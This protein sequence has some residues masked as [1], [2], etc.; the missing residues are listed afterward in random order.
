M[1]LGVTTLF[2]LTVVI[3]CRLLPHE[4]TP[5]DAKPPNFDSIRFAS[6]KILLN[7]LDLTAMVK[8]PSLEFSKFHCAEFSFPGLLSF[9]VTLNSTLVL[10]GNISFPVECV[11]LL[12]DVIKRGSCAK[13]A[14][15][16]FTP[17]ALVCPA[18]SI[19]NSKSQMTHGPVENV[20]V[21]L[22][23]SLTPLVTLSLITLSR[24]SCFMSFSVRYVADPS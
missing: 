4:L 21:R 17:D 2:L 23:L 22:C 7:S 3:F 19:L 24:P 10:Q 12:S 18:A 13:C 5:S 16:G 9:L 11:Q 8:R 20:F 1:N 15:T 6:S 14:T